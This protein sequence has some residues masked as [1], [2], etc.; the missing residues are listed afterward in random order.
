MGLPNGHKEIVARG[1]TCEGV[2]LEPIEEREDGSPVGIH[3]PVGAAFSVLEPHPEDAH[4]AGT[5]QGPYEAAVRPR[6]GPGIVVAEVRE[7]GHQSAGVP[8]GLD[9]CAEGAAKT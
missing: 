7:R 3:N 5:E 1:F 6:K 2:V 9:H 4:L 8:D